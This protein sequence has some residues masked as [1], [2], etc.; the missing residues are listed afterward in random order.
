MFKAIF[1]MLMLVMVVSCTPIVAYKHQTPQ[2]KYRVPDTVLVSV[3]DN[4]E[5]VQR[6][7]NKNFI[8]IYRRNFGIIFDQSVKGLI[9]YD[10]IDKKGGL[11]D[12]LQR[13]LVDG[14]NSNNW[15]A[16]SFQ[17]SEL[18]S[19]SSMTEILTKEKATKFLVII[20][21]EW[22]FDTDMHFITSFNFDTDVDVI[23]Y[24]PLL[25][26]N[27]AL[28]VARRK[29]I[30]EHSDRYND[31]IYAYKKELARIMS[32]DKIKKA[33]I[34]KASYLDR[35]LSHKERIS[36]QPAKITNKQCTGFSINSAGVI[37]VAE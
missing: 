30:T 15:M 8:G 7:K 29:I 24:D 27:L 31:V 5:R 1:L 28:N 21:N 20:L 6:G 35:S 33:L 10:E 23:V 13:R 4:R 3:I 9:A 37:T 32:I 26:D 19:S 12:F 2:I 18:P 34:Y 22:F 36:G 25:E 16:K 11:A 14:L 17:L